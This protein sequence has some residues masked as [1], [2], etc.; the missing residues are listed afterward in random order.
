MHSAWAGQPPYHSG[1]GENVASPLRGPQGYPSGGQLA[2]APPP[3]I[4]GDMDL[5]AK[6][7]KH[8][9]TRAPP[10][11]AY[12]KCPFMSKNMGGKGVL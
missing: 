2:R 10:L 9:A 3:T 11:P 7:W 5:L 6:H 4:F 12:D 8:T 1:Y